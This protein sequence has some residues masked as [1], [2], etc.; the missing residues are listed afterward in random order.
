M[1]Y[2]IFSALFAISLLSGEE[3]A[4][5]NGLKVAFEKN[6]ADEEISILMIA[7]GGYGQIPIQ[8]QVAAR[9]ASEVVWEAGFGDK[10]SDQISNFLYANTFDLL[11]DTYPFYRKIE[12]SAYNDNLEV[13]FMLIKDIFTKPRLDDLKVA[14]S[15]LLKGFDPGASDAEETFEDR[16][17]SINTRDFPP[18][19]PIT[20][21]EVEKVDLAKVEA[22]YKMAFSNPS[23]FV[24]VV[25]GDFD[26]T[27]LKAIL[28][29]TLGTIPAQPS[30]FRPLA[31]WPSFP[32]GITKKTISK[33]SRG[34]PI[35]RLTF[36][37]NFTFNEENL[38]QLEYVSETIEAH[39]RE[40]LKTTLNVVDVGYELPFYPYTHSVWL[41]IQIQDKND[42]AYK[43]VIDELKNMLKNGPDENDLRRAYEQI[44][45][46]NEYWKQ[47]NAYLASRD[48]NQ[49]LWGLP[50]K[51]RKP[52]PLSA[53][54][55]KTNLNSWINLQN[56]SKVYAK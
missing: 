33:G 26:E 54:V 36:P 41:S 27:Q 9:V 5:K 43:A 13:L 23:E 25:V 39:M 29:N 1:K 10:N 15:H 6:L 8:D 48:S 46:S 12:A 37:L 38:Y 35:T 2:I 17:K 44:V 22:F 31:K 51:E 7:K 56:Y 4:L 45:H 47:D 24:L 20:K 52:S 11:I 53:S 55:V 18:F 50:I 49:L 14:L 42:E 40:K 3:F 28:E 16:I 30:A 32:D 21:K 34:E 19:R